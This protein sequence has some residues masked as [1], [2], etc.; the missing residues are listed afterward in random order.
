MNVCDD[1]INVLVKEK[2]CDDKINVL[3]KGK[4]NTRA[5]MYTHV[6]GNRCV[7]YLG[8]MFTEYIY[9]CDGGRADV[10]VKGDETACRVIFS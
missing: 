5:L 4:R 2:V 9:F 6:W 3:V 1:K 7:D 8:H 10:V